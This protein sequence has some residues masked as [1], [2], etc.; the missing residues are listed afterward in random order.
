MAINLPCLLKVLQLFFTGRERESRDGEKMSGHLAAAE[1]KFDQRRLTCLLFAIF[2]IPR[3]NQACA[4]DY[5]LS[6]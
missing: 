1:E 3:F 6:N 5:F 4:V 2:I